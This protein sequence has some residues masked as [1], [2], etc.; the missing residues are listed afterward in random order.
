LKGIDTM[1]EIKKVKSKIENIV[2]SAN[3]RDS[4]NNMMIETKNKDIHGIVR[5]VDTSNLYE[6]LVTK[7]YIELCGLLGEKVRGGKSKECRVKVWKRWFL[8]EKKRRSYVIHKIYDTPIEKV[9]NRGGNNRIYIDKAESL[10]INLLNNSGKTYF[11]NTQLLE[12]IGLIN[13]NYKYARNVQHSLAKYLDIDKEIIENFYDTISSRLLGI[14]NSALNSL[15]K[16]GVISWNKEFMLCDENYKYE[17]AQGRKKELIE[18]VEASVLEEMKIK[19]I[20]QVMYS[21]LLKKFTERVCEIINADQE[22]DIKIKFYYRT[23]ALKII[24]NVSETI[25][26][27]ILNKCKIELNKIFI[28]RYRL[29]TIDK[30]KTIQSTEE[31]IMDLIFGVEE[32]KKLDKLLAL[33]NNYINILDKMLNTIV[34]IGG[35]DI[36]RKLN[37]IK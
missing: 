22:D 7:N 29:N 2:Y 15:S 26:E 35:E 19:H 1:E 36:R 4:K 21:G 24:F 27:N 20:G 25:D 28:E 18:E 14:L 6:G 10:I 8:F 13:I 9:E 17:I 5:E 23:N 32:G 12:E 30:I 37:S 31:F 3:K 34:E 11:T 16:D 33:E